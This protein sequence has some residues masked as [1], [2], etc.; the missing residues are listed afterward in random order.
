[1]EYCSNT[2]LRQEDAKL[3]V[4]EPS[5]SKQQP[6]QQFLEADISLTKYQGEGGW[7]VL[8]EGQNRRWNIAYWWGMTWT[9]KVVFS[10]GG[11]HPLSVVSSR[12][13]DIQI[14]IK[15]R[16]L[17]GKWCRQLLKSPLN[18]FP[19]CRR[20]NFCS[21]LCSIEG[22]MAAMRT[23]CQEEYSHFLTVVCQGN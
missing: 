8:M 21:F 16:G 2:Y 15:Q 7:M 10:S 6:I 22:K 12:G 13:T 23:I 19:I 1:M 4:F 17:S 14:I 3:C 9:F 20:G 11:H 18:D 5:F